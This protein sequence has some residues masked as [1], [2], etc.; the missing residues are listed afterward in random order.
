MNLVLIVC[1]LH[2]LGQRYRQLA[3]I[4]EANFPTHWHCLESTYIVKTALEPIAVRDLVG[5]A[6]DTNDELLV[7]RLVE[8]TWAVR[9][10]DEPCRAWLRNHA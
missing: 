8:S 2:K 10:F 1:D 6:I 7:I 3:S 5:K 9:G 4:V